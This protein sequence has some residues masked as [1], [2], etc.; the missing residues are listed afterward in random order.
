M[1][2]IDADKL[3][4]DIEHYNLS[5]GKFQHWVEIQPT[6][7][8]QIIRCEDCEYSSPNHVYGCRLEPFNVN[9]KGGRMYSNDYCS[10]AERRGE[11]E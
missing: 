1:R 5:D 4:R 2:L 8:P 3:L 6:V 7:E 10:K 9:E 11:Q